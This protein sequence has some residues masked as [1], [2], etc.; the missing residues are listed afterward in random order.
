[1]SLQGKKILLGVSGSIAAYKAAYLVRE[2]TGRGAEVQVIA[3]EGAGRFIAPLTL[4]TLSKRPCLTAFTNDSRTDWNNHVHLGLWADA[5]VIAPATAN[6]LAK[7]AS[8][9]CD[10]LLTAVYLSARC[11]VY[12]APAMD[13]DMWGHAATQHN[14][15]TLL[16][17]GVRLIPVESGELAS[18]LNGP[19]RMAEP[20]TIAGMLEADL[21]ADAGSPLKGRR[22]LITAG[23]TYE[24]IDPVRFIGN[25][26]T[27]R[28][29]I[30][31]ADEA[32]RRGAVVTLVLGPSPHSPTCPGVEVVRVTSGREMLEACRARYVDTDM[33]IFAA[34]VADYAP[35]S[36][37]AQKIKKRGDTLRLDLVKTDDIAADFG[38]SKREGQLSVGFA[39]E[40]EREEEHAREK[41]LAKHFDLIVLNSL[42]DEGAGFRHETNR[43]TLMD[44]HNNTERY[45][46]KSKALVA[47]DILKKVETLL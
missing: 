38:R 17:R 33:A 4:A 46:L 26:S 24:A 16:G 30:A 44:R 27:G 28:M 15:A 10:N 43:V 6:T 47:A 7:M 25:H 36:P 31:L 21:S 45:E 14:I 1:M 40:T 9:L 11:P 39:L 3:T 8:G 42:N 29:G 22:V 13:E 18:G 5:L 32:C 23:P 34:A 41:L 20:Q 19:G 37:E 35:A 12:I 2:L